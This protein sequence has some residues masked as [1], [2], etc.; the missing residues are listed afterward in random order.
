MNK[1]L[2][3]AWTVPGRGRCCEEAFGTPSAREAGWLGAGVGAYLP[4]EGQRGFGYCTKGLILITLTLNSVFR[5]LLENNSETW[6]VTVLSVFAKDVSFCPHFVSQKYPSPIINRE[7]KK[8]GKY[9][10]RLSD[11]LQ[12]K[13]E[14]PFFSVVLYNLFIV[15]SPQQLSLQSRGLACLM[16]PKL[17]ISFS[18]LIESLFLHFSLQVLVSMTITLSKL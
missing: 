11:K 4:E 15:Q 14:C 7:K 13:L 18:K 10:K 8:N 9:E 17:C 5:H 16:V 12:M 2:G 6:Q 3:S 1:L